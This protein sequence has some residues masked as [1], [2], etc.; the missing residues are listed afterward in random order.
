MKEPFF[1]RGA[2][3]SFVLMM[4]LYLFIWFGIYAVIVARG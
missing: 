4:V 2:I 1:P 3:A